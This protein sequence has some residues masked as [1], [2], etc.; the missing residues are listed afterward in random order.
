MKTRFPKSARRGAIR[1]PRRDKRKGTDSL[2]RQWVVCGK[3]KHGTE[4]YFHGNS[5]NPIGGAFSRKNATV[6]QTKFAADE[7]ARKL[8]PYL[9]GIGLTELTSKAI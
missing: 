1:N 7:V 9:Y 3:A 2:G 5:R 6:F 8:R 4:Y